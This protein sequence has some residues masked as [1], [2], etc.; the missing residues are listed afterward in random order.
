MA[1]LCLLPC[2]EKLGTKAHEMRLHNMLSVLYGC[3]SLN[4]NINITDDQV[5]C[6]FFQLLTFRM[7]FQVF[8]SFLVN[9]NTFSFR[10]LHFCQF[11]SFPYSSLSLWLCFVNFSLVLFYLHL[12]H[13]RSISPFLSL[14]SPLLF[15]YPSTPDLLS[16]LNLKRRYVPVS[17][18]YLSFEHSFIYL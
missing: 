13:T 8:C 2:L 1:W 6:F 12:S 16:S 4:G 14:S 18:P 17:L 10:A 3:H 11:S 9:S 5:C 7:P 15:I